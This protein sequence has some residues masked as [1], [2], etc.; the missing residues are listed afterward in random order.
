MCLVGP[1]GTAGKRFMAVLVCLFYIVKTRKD[2][3]ARSSRTISWCTPGGPRDEKYR[4]TSPDSDITW[5]LCAFIEK[6]KSKSLRNGSVTYSP[7]VQ[8]YIL[9]KVRLS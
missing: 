8:T 2:E 4:P 7:Q 5:G 3:N 1:E 9:E 6:L